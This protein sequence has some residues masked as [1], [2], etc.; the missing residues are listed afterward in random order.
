MKLGPPWDLTQNSTLEV[1]MQM[2]ITELCPILGELGGLEKVTY[3]QPA[4]I[5]PNLLEG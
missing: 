3:M 1:H 2:V 4:A 5:E